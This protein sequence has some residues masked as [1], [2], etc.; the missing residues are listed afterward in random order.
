VSEVRNAS[1]LRHGIDEPAERNPVL[2]MPA[3]GTIIC[4]E[5]FPQERHCNQRRPAFM[6]GIGCYWGMHCFF[7]LLGS[8]GY[9]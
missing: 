6:R 4:G 2:A 3:A 1:G 9:P 8:Y 5:N 7:A